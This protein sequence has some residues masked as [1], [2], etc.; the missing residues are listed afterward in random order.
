MNIRT[1]FFISE[2]VVFSL[3]N[4]LFCLCIVFNFQRETLLYF[5]RFL[6]KNKRSFKTIAQS[7]ICN[8]HY[9]FVFSRVK[10]FKWLKIIKFLTWNFTCR[11]FKILYKECKTHWKCVQTWIR[12]SVINIMQQC[13]ITELPGRYQ[14]SGSYSFLLARLQLQHRMDF[15][16]EPPTLRQKWNE[17]EF[18]IDYQG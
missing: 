6:L 13:F 7:F 17:R 18:S 11:F 5:G 4:L 15:F 10:K 1:S 12:T 14:L 16:Q 3:S 8:F 9:S 2:S